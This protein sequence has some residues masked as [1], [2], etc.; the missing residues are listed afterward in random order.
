[1]RK[2]FLLLFTLLIG[3][4]INANAQPSVTTFPWTEGFE[5]TTFPPSGWSSYNIGG[6]PMGWRRSTAANFIHTGGGA[7]QHPMEENALSW[8]VTPKMAIPADGDNFI[9]EFWSYISYPV[10]YEYSGVWVS[11]TGNDPTASVFTEIKALG[12]AEIAAEYQ[13]I[14]VSLSAYAGQEVYIAFKFDGDDPHG[15]FIDDVMIGEGEAGCNPIIAF[16]WTEGF[17]NGIPNCWENIDADGD[18]HVWEWLDFGSESYAVSYSMDMSSFAALTPDNYLVTPQ[19]LL[20]EDAVLSFEVMTADMSSPAEK[21]SVLISTTGTDLD[22]F[23]A[24]HTETLTVSDLNP[25]TVTLSLSSYA[26]ENIYI[27]FRHWDSTMQAAIA[28]DN[29]SVSVQPSSDCNPITTFPWTEGFVDGIPDC[30]EIIDADG[31]G[32]VWEWL[33]LGSESYAA[34]FSIDMSS[35]SALTPDNYLITPQIVLSEDCELSFEVM[36]GDP[37]LPADKYSV[38]V[39]TTGTAIEDFTAIHT[40]TLTIADIEAKLVTLSLSNYTGESIY[41]AFRHWDCTGQVAV[42]ID[43]VSV[44]VHSGSDCQPITTFPWTEGFANG[45]PDCW[46]NVDADGDGHKWEWLDMG[47]ENF[48]ASFSMDM[49]TP[50]TPDNYLITPQL[51]LSEECDLKF[52]VMTAD[53]TGYAEKYAVMVSTTGTA[54]GDFTAIHTETLTIADIEARTV[55]LSLSDYVGESIYIAFRHWDSTGQAAIVLDNMSVSV[56]TIALDAEVAS[57]PAPNSGQLTD[58][59]NVKVIIKNNGTEAITGFSLDLTIDGTLVAN[60]TYSGTIAAAGQAEYTFTATADLSAVGDHAITVTVN[61]EG[62]ET[63]SNNTLTKTVT[64]STGCA[65]ISSYPWTEGFEGAAFPPECWTSYDIDRGGSSWYR[66]SDPDFVDIYVYDGTASAGHSYWTEQEGWLVTPKF[67]IPEEANDFIFE[68]WSYIGSPRDYEYSGVWV[69]TTG[70]DPATSTFTEVK[71]LEGDEIT[72]SYVKIAIPL[73]DYAGQNIYIGFKYVSDFAHTWY[74]DNVAVIN[75]DSF[76]DVEVASITSPNSGKNLI[77]EE[78]TAVIVNNGSEPVSNVPVGLKVNGLE[79]A[80]ETIPSIAALSQEE[81]TFTQTADFSVGGEFTIEVYTALEGDEIESNN[82]FTKT[83]NNLLCPTIA[84]FPWIE[85]F[86]NGIS[87]CWL[88]VDAD[89]DY[90]KWYESIFNDNHVVVSESSYE[91][92]PDLSHEHNPGKWARY[93]DNYL[94][95]PPIALD[96]DYSLSFKVGSTHSIRYEEHYSVLVSTTGTD[97][98]DFTEIHSET[99]SSDRLKT[100]AVSLAEYAGETIYIAFRHWNCSD[101]HAIILDDV[102]VVDLNTYIDLEVMAITQPVTDINLDNESVTAIIQNNGGKEISGFTLTLNVNGAD[103]VTESYQGTL[104]P[105]AQTEYT[106]IQTA[107][108]SA[109]G[110]Y[111]IKVTVAHEDDQMESNNSAEVTI[112]NTVCDQITSFPW[113]EGFDNGISEC[114]RNIDADGDKSAWIAT[115]ADTGPCVISYSAYPGGSNPDNYLITPQIALT[116]NLCLL[117]FDIA[118]WSENFHAEK[119]SVLISTTGASIEDFTSIYTETISSFGDRTITLILDEYIGETIYIAFR[120]W[121]CS[122][123]KAL[124]LDNVTVFEF[125]DVID[126]EISEIIKPH[127]GKL[128]DAEEVTVTINNNGSD[129]ISNFTLRLEV[130]GAEVALETY[131]GTIGILSQAQYTFNQT[132]NLSEIG[133]HIIRVTVDIDNDQVP[134]NNTLSKT[135]ANINDVMLYGFRIYDDVFG[136]VEELV[137]FNS[138]NPGTVTRVSDYRDGTNEIIGGEF[139]DGTLYAYSRTSAG[140]AANFIKLSTKTWTATTIPVSS[141]CTDMAYDY[142]TDTMYGISSTSNISDLY[143]INIED[144]EK[145]HIGS[146]GTLFYTLACNLQGEMFGI[147]IAGNFCSINKATGAATVIASTGIVPYYIQSMAFDHNS[148]RLLWAMS[149]ED[150]DGR[151]IEIDPVTAVVFDLGMIGNNSEIVA[152]YT[153]FYVTSIPSVFG[154]LDDIGMYPNPAV[155][156]VNLTN[157][158]E[159]AI[160]TIFDFT[161]RKTRTFTANSTLVVNIDFPAGFYFVEIKGKQGSVTKK[162]IVK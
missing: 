142:T 9:L 60:E 36:I 91:H 115:V 126:A 135:V 154:T 156:K 95:T 34:S 162:L 160:V 51:V 39:S 75:L 72:S 112:F 127:H 54:P 134:D 141:S 83:I 65:P 3:Y 2:L 120:H 6:T 100:V 109:A 68:F 14:T 116:D 78:V 80:A 41:I 66:E 121:D 87:D 153:P 56:Y 38:L 117:Q 151:L 118:A 119:Y 136:G 130:D 10:G 140:I 101:Q 94:I 150:G 79:V 104:G 1:M 16:P 21:Y 86:D 49:F 23:T 12:G 131:T 11:T 90:A 7:A 149:H 122:N 46:G 81:Y 19:I 24:L 47:G 114:W 143:T 71:V 107:D 55:T 157:L 37:T 32:H 57:M 8:L 82:S 45:V 29:V 105:L 146:L 40:E 139:Y 155:D 99:L 27:A 25:R 144:G 13:K 96:D 70:N 106:F 17:A 20:P 113:K 35:F 64:T 161:G 125:V 44:A 74:I 22:D 62:D 89:G 52:D 77:H 138:N 15:W 97:L 103:L 59:E 26:G 48:I 42:V 58:T 93:P 128:T 159:N 33:E 84:T 133:N 145:T 88:N 129:P 5:D 61:L 102:M 67:E 147:D 18:G 137:S 98:E 4:P 92:N 76:I 123:Q 43:N 31:D 108:L 73:A 53:P 124:V 152:L 148:G 30:W 110:E 132:V 158:P 85:N 50:L 28:I 63:P 69:S 111:V